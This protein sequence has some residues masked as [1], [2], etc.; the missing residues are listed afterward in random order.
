MGRY[1]TVDEFVSRVGEREALAIA[2][3][4]AFN[5]AEGRSIDRTEIETELR[6]AEDLVGGYVLVRHPWL[7]EVTVDAV[8][9][10]LKGLTSDIL[11][12]RLRDKAGN[13]GQITE[14]VERRYRDALTM[15]RDI[16]QG[17]LDLVR[18]DLGQPATIAADGSGLTRIAGPAPTVDDT[19]Q[20]WL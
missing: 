2:G 20:G 9:N 13:T 17:K 8:P 15:L 1:L 5:S 18:E 7:V 6:H 11:R 14:T 4:G 12:Y 10:L 16:Q 3:T 19:L